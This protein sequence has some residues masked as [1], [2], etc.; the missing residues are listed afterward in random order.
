MILALTDQEEYDGCD[1]TCTHLTKIGTIISTMRV[2]REVTEMNQISGAMKRIKMSAGTMSS[3]R[4]Q[5]DAYTQY[6][7]LVVLKCECWDELLL[8]VR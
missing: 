2:V 4:D 1:Y 8:W 3:A 5:Q 7:Q 6:H